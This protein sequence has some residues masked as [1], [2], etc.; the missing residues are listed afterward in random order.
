MA[1]IVEKDAYIQKNLSSVMCG[2]LTQNDF[3]PNQLVILFDH[4]KTILEVYKVT[5]EYFYKTKILI[6]HC[7]EGKI[8]GVN[9]ITKFLKRCGIISINSFV[10]HF[11]KDFKMN[12]NSHKIE[13]N[14]ITFIK[15]NIYQLDFELESI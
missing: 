9:N 4:T 15:F 7:G 10:I 6:I 1:Y 13:L 8:S 14:L 3:K 2:F 12:T 11:S 5:F